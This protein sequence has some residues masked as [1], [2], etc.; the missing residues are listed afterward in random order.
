MGG[1]KC[2]RVVVAP[3]SINLF[4]FLLLVSFFFPA[5]L[6]PGLKNELFCSSTFFSEGEKTR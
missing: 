4:S 6:T 1:R 5:V 2:A 3:L